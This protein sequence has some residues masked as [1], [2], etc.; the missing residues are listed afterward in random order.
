MLPKRDELVVGDDRG[1]NLRCFDAR[2]TV[3]S[4][5]I[6]REQR[7]AQGGENPPVRVQSIDVPVGDPAVQVRVQI[8]YVLGF[9]GID[10]PRYVQVVVI[11]WVSYLAFGTIRE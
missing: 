2:C 6:R 4:P 11:G 8:V 10:V 3:A 9:A 5:A 7:F 1:T